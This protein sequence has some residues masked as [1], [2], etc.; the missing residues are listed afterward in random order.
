MTRHVHLERQEECEGYKAPADSFLEIGYDSNATERALG[1]VLSALVITLG[2]LGSV[3]GIMAMALGSDGTGGP[4]GAAFLGSGTA[5]LILGVIGAV[6]FGSW[7]DTAQIE[8]RPY[9]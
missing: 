7:G 4:I 3:G 5:L 1:G 9:R 8:V 6:A 2:M